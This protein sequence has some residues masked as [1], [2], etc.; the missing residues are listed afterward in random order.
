M[1]ADVGDVVMVTLE[2]PLEVFVFGAILV[3]VGSK[4]MQVSGVLYARGQD[5][6]AVTL[7]AVLCIMVPIIG[8]GLALLVQS[9]Q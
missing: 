1:A 9:A 8:L 5:W 6:Y 3:F 4:L 7:A 2:L